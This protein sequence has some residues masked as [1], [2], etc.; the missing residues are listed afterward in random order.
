M[1]YWLWSTHNDRQLRTQFLFTKNYNSFFFF[2]KIV[3]SFT[4]SHTSHHHHHRRGP[5]IDETNCNQRWNASCPHFLL[6][7][8]YQ[9]KESVYW[10][11][12][13]LI[14]IFFLKKDWIRRAA[15]GAIFINR[16]FTS[17]WAS[18]IEIKS[19]TLF[20]SFLCSFLLLFY[21]FWLYLCT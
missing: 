12:S 15:N 11:Y 19:K 21:Q 16:I 2:Q 1:T 5:L 9:K 8:Q 10:I 17:N 14:F 13:Y 7:I 6:N 3:L 20:F 4:Y 18:M